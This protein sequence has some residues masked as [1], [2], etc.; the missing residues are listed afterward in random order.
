MTIRQ[1][2]ALL[3][4]TFPR[5]FPR[6]ELEKLLVAQL[7][8]R[9]ALDQS[10]PVRVRSPRMILHICAGNLAISAQTS[11]MH[12]LLLGSENIVKL[13]SAHEDNTTRQ[14]INDFIRRLPASLRSLVKTCEDAT[15]HLPNAEAI[16]AFGS[17]ATMQEL[18]KNIRWDQKFL[19]HGHA[20]SLLWIGQP[21]TPI[22]ARACAKDILTYDQLGCLSPQAIYFEPK[23]DP[24]KIG[25][26]LALALE[27]E[28]LRHQAKRP[29]SI[30][31]RIT[32]ARD[33]AH[34]RGH[35]VWAA[36]H[37]GWTVI[38]TSESG[39]HPS[40]LHGVIYLRP[41]HQLAQ[42]LRAVRG[43]ISTVGLVG[44]LSAEHEKTFLHLGITRFC[45]AGKMQTP[46]LTWHHDGR[47]ILADLVTW[48]DREKS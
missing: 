35:R 41:A 22:S 39:F 5:Q 15:A 29:L 14:D 40:P 33:I 13:P 25:A 23:L 30:A 38:L 8:H 10:C 16:I 31:A 12:G 20:V 36:S 27:K 44:K 46:P 1:R 37:L 43:K 9:D 21:L 42:S 34:A 2:V 26:A 18:R 48:I 3:A 11:L 17:D 28:W 47:P 32:E 24:E 6:R 45:S 19:P 7:G 4:Q